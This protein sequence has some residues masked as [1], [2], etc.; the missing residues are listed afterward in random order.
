M[1]EKDLER[2]AVRLIAR[3]HW[4]QHRRK[5]R[6]RQLALGALTWAI[7]AGTLLYFLA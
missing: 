3:K 7:A 2:A 5:H 6:Q 4:Q 1:T